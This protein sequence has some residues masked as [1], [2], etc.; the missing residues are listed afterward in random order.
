MTNL[1][2][3]LITTAAKHPE[4]AALRVNGQGDHL[5]PA[6]RHGRQGRGS[7]ARQRHPARRPGGDHPAQRA[8][9]PRRLLGHPA[10][11]RRRRADEPAAQGRR[12][13]VLLQRLRRADRL[14]LARLR[15]RGHQGRGRRPAPR[16]SSAARWA[17]SRAASRAATPIA[18]PHERADD[19]T[20]VILYTSGTTGRPKGAELTHG[21]IHLN[22]TR[23]AHDDPGDHPRRRRHGLPAAVPRLRPGRR[24]QRRDA[25]PARAW[26][27]SPAS[28]RP[29]PSR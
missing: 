5:R 11:R 25:S 18:E 21:N 20:A 29:R 12:D 15:G 2:T 22:A 1:A 16:S 7:L 10:R 19:D 14:R 26:P 3:N 23:S 13:R 4:Q 28:T 27:S 24:P 8:G 9:V 17:R 6:A